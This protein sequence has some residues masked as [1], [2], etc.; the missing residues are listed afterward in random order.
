MPQ[1]TRPYFRSP[2]NELNELFLSSQNDAITLSA[3][4]AELQHRDRPAAVSLRGDVKRRLNELNGQ[5]TAR[6]KS[7]AGRDSAQDNRLQPD[8]ESGAPMAGSSAT[9]N[10]RSRSG[11]WQD[12]HLRR[13]AHLKRIEPLGV[14]GRP[15]KYV[16]PLKTDV[17]LPIKSN[18]PRAARYALALG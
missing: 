2:F 15:S 5:G 14:A 12:N 6:E 16:R 17:D 4:L 1:R 13:P 8:T 7:Q 10:S 11:S 3:L 18:M 9:G